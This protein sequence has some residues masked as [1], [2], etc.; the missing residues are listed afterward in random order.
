MAMTRLVFSLVLLAGFAFPA[1]A[2][3]AMIFARDAK[4]HV[5]QEVSV[6]GDI[7][8]VRDGDGATYVFLDGRGRHAALTLIFYGDDAGMFPGL[9][10]ATGRS[11]LA[12]GRIQLVRGQPVMVIRRHIQLTF[13]D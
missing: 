10:T 1:S 7:S 12:E 11:V 5:G 4:A 6:R 13:Q 2:L 3:P 8:G 9:D